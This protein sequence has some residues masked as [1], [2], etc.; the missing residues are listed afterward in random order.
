MKLKA[1][2]C[3]AGLAAPTMLGSAP[4]S[5]AGRGHHGHRR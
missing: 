4:A 2:L 1:R 5:W 3:I